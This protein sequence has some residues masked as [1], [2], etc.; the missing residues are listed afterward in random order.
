MP[1]R[2]VLQY[3]PNKH[4]KEQ[5]VPNVTLSRQITNTNV[6]LLRRQI[7]LDELFN[8]F[9]NLGVEV[10]A[11]IF[12]QRNTKGRRW[13]K[14]GRRLKHPNISKTFYLGHHALRIIYWRIIIMNYEFSN[15]KGNKFQI[16]NNPDTRIQDNEK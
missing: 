3:S 5:H 2:N 12:K 13:F 10:R 16:M 6:T 9:G 15:I 11:N 4:Q 8:V 7:E 14:T 1:N